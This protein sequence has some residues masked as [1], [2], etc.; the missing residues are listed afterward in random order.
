MLNGTLTPGDALHDGEV[1]SPYPGEFRLQSDFA[2]ARYAFASHALR[3]SLLNRPF[4]SQ[5]PTDGMR[6]AEVDQYAYLSS[7]SHDGEVMLTVCATL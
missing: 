2:I 7:L 4:S 6:V 5:R 3:A 1:L